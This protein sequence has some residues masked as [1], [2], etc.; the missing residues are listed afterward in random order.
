MGWTET[1][2]M[3]Y[4]I[5]CRTDGGIVLRQKEDR[6]PGYVMHL[7]ESQLI[8]DR[9]KNRKGTDW[10]KAFLLGSLLPDTRLK[11]EKA[12]SHFWNEKYLED[13]AKAPDLELF[14]KKYKSRLDEPLILGYYLHLYLDVCYVKD[15]WPAKLSFEN[16]AGEPEKKKAAITDVVICDRGK[17]VPLSEF[18]TRKYYYGDYTRSNGWFIRHYQIRTPEYVAIRDIHMDEVE[19]EDVKGLLEELTWLC[20][21]AEEHAGSNDPLQ[22]FDISSLDAF[23]HDTAEKFWKENS[24]LLEPENI[25]A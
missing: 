21:M 17:K 12:I 4:N 2:S 7:V 13:I 3:K 14:L 19:L 8:L 24:R 23:L 9:M 15:Y 1:V 6:M 22:V 25:K 10:E 5:D 20:R 11:S 16:A 18:F